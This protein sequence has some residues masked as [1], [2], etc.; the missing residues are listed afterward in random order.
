MGDLTKGTADDLSDSMLG[1]SA[2][3]LGSSSPCLSVILVQEAYSIAKAL[4]LSGP[5]CHLVPSL[6]TECYST[7]DTLYQNL[8]PEGKLYPSL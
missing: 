4:W 7:E 1:I 3:R 5:L 2:V 6:Q 8:T